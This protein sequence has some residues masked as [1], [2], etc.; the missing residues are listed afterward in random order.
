MLVTF[1]V[2][3]VGQQPMV[4][5]MRCLLWWTVW[6][7]CNVQSLVCWTAAYGGLYEVLV[8]FKVWYV[9]QQAMVDCVG[10]L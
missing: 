4:D 10:C 2:W 8:T 6:G 7:A 3:Y 1:K 9:G 5:C